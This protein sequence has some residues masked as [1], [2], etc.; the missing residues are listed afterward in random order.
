MQKCFENNLTDGLQEI[1]KTVEKQAK[2]TY[3]REEKQTNKKCTKMEEGN[4]LMYVGDPSKPLISNSE[5]DF[6]KSHCFICLDGESNGVTL[7]SCCSICSAQVHKKCWFSYRRVQKLSALRSK[8]LMIRKQDP[9]TCSVC[10]TGYAKINEEND[11]HWVTN[12]NGDKE[13]LQDELLRTIGYILANDANNNDATTFPY[14]YIFIFNVV[15]ITLLIIVVI[16][17]IFAFGLSANY[18]LLT[19][20]FIIYEV[21]T[22]E[23]IVYFCFMIRNNS[24]R[25]PLNVC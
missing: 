15:F 4:L 12:E 8:L 19:S 13:D 20:F 25:F 2:G 5:V 9:L 7:F 24:T 3:E 16:I 21:I 14:R 6:K 17:M 18:V 1:G 22:V 10:K 23:L 11:V